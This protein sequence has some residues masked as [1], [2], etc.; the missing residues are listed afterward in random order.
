[1]RLIKKTILIT[2]ICVIFIIGCVEEKV[3][4][5]EIPDINASTS[6]GQEQETESPTQS[7][8]TISTVEATATQIPATLSSKNLKIMTNSIKMEFLLIPEGEFKMGALPDEKFRY[9]QEPVH[10]VKIEKAYYLG[11]YEVTQ[12]QWREVMGN[13]PSNFKGDNLPVEKVS[14]KDVQEF[15]KKLNEKEETDKYRLPS[16]AKWEYAARAGTTTHYSFGDNDSDLADYAWYVGNSGD[17][18]HPVGQKQPNPWGLHD[19]HG[20]VWEWVQ[21]RE[22]NYDV[23]PTDGSAYESGSS[24]YRVFRGGSWLMDAKYCRSAPRQATATGIHDFS[25]GFRLMKEM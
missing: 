7:P 9:G 10:I 5:T 21:D 24:S 13:N 16:E 19:M 22:H 25:L 12:K 15:I 20:N 18:T 8:A 11:K 14:W 6:S 2:L 3:T 1:M 17:K 23:S 4:S